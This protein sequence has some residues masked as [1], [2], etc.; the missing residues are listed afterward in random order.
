MP[1]RAAR[2]HRNWKLRSFKKL[3]EPGTGNP[4]KVFYQDVGSN[5]TIWD[6]PEDGQVITNGGHAPSGPG[7][8]PHPRTPVI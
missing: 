1:F 2:A 6:L 8:R 4:G 7:Q 5:Q 3:L